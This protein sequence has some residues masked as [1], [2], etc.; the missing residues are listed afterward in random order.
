MKHSTAIATVLFLA[1]TAL[2]AAEEESGGGGLFSVE[3]GLVLWTVAVFLIVLAVLRKFAWAPII[4]ALDLREASIRESIE[5][6]ARMRTEAAGLLEEHRR[7][8]AEARAQSQEIV[9]QGREAGERLRREI[10]TKAREESDR[11]LE[12]ARLE[13]ARERDQAVDTLRRESVDL[14]IALASRLLQERLDGET[15][16]RLIE[17]YLDQLG[18]PAAEA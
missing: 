18:T 3:P 11:M 13:I 4:G 6:A 17:G 15:D 8:I 2:A 10:E 1:P 14:A 16:R 9:A 7:Q 5:T 12:R